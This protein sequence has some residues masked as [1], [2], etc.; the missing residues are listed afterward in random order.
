MR[1]VGFYPAGSYRCSCPCAPGLRV[2]DRGRCDRSSSSSRSCCVLVSAVL[3]PGFLTCD[4]DQLTQRLPQG[5][6]WSLGSHHFTRSGRK[7]AVCRGRHHVVSQGDLRGIQPWE[8]PTG[9][10]FGVFSE[11]GV[12]THAEFL[13]AQAC[14]L[15]SAVS[16][17]PGVSFCSCSPACAALCCPVCFS[18]NRPNPASF[19]FFF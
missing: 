11:N 18:S 19:F 6:T 8:E 1:G 15:D 13:C 10:L 9:P 5:R 4:G 12:L 7:P 14:N 3:V 2:S 17:G 16:R